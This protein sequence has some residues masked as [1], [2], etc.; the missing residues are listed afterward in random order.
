MGFNYLKP[1]FQKYSICVPLRPL[2]V[3]FRNRHQCNVTYRHQYSIIF[4][5]GWKGDQILKYRFSFIVMRKMLPEFSSFVSVRYLRY[6]IC[7]LVKYNIV[8]ATLSCWITDIYNY[9]FFIF[10]FFLFII[11]NYNI[12]NYKYISMVEAN[13]FVKSFW[14]VLTQLCWLD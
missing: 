6:L 8:T 10:Y 5:G 3:C 1:K 9:N 14:I 11:I 12:C 2:L 13:D 4:W 7:F